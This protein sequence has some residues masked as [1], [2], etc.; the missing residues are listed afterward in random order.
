MWLKQYCTSGDNSTHG[1]LKNEQIRNSYVWTA[2][3]VLR[4][5]QLLHHFCL[6]GLQFHCAGALGIANTKTKNGRAVT[7]LLVAGFQTRRL[8]FEPESCHVGHV[9]GKAAVVQVK[10]EYSISPVTHT[11]HQL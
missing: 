8:G 11:F 4:E 6:A 3:A 7:Q 1:L 5:R 2:P 10:S 9:V